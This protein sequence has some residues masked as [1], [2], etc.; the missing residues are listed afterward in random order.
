MRDTTTDLRPWARA[1]AVGV[2]AGDIATL[3][4]GISDV[5]LSQLVSKMQKR[6]EARIRRGSPHQVGGELLLRRAGLRPSSWIGRY[7]AKL[8]FGALYGVMWGALYTVVRRR[9]PRALA[10]TA[11]L[12]FV[13]CDGGIAPT[14]GLTPGLPR[15]PWQFNVKEFFNHL[16]WNATAEFIHARD[17]RAFERAVAV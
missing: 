1:L 2:L 17:Q 8:A 10:P 6:R 9:F 11:A 15:I 13:A 12:F 5:L 3:T 16:A 7:G 14:L 4:S